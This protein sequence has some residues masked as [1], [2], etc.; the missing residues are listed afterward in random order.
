MLPRVSSQVIA[1]G[2]AWRRLML[3]RD[4]VRFQRIEGPFG[5]NLDRLGVLA[6]AVEN[7]LSASCDGT[8]GLGRKM[9]PSV[10]NM[11]STFS[12]PS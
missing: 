9:L 12:W 4:G 7:D 1:G 8:H 2:R 5:M 11:R 10:P 6:G 3:S